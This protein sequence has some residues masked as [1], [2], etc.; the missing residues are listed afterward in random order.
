MSLDRVRF[1]LRR[2]AALRYNTCQP[3]QISRRVFEDRRGT[4]C[5]WWVFGTTVQATGRTMAK[6]TKAATP[7]PDRRKST[8]AAAV[9]A[10]VAPAATISDAEIARRA[11]EVYCAR[12]GQHGRDL[13]DWLQAERELRTASISTN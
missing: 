13:D 6:T 2:I 3:H 4:K 12:G 1:F 10:I 11:F 5:F 7:K 9:A 8:K